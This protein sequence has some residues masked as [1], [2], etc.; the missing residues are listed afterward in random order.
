MCPTC[1][2]Q[3]GVSM[4]STTKEILQQAQHDKTHESILPINLCAKKLF[5]QHIISK[6]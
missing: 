4:W 2:P 1:Q 6:P 5:Q 3:A